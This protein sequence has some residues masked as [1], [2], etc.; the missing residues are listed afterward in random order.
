ME[1]AY[2]A[3][4]SAKQPVSETRRD[5]NGLPP[6]PPSTPVP[7]QGAATNHNAPVPTATTITFPESQPTEWGDD[8]IFDYI[9]EIT[10][11]PVTS[12][13]AVPSTDTTIAAATTDST[14]P[15][16]STPQQ[17]ERTTTTTTTKSRMSHRL[18]L[19]VEGGQP[20]PDTSCSP[21][22]VCPATSTASSKTNAPQRDINDFI[23]PIKRYAN[24]D[25]NIDHKR[26]F[27]SGKVAFMWQGFPVMKFG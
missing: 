11:V 3:V 6:A 16:V 25:P 1:I 17:G 22:P 26:K 21:T 10:E 2:T 5:L 12:P 7:D 9:P 19:D 20:M 13:S 23:L 18:K 15:S 24:D 27:A 14:T 4:A 8:S